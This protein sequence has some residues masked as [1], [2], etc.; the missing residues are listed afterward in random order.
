VDYTEIAVWVPPLFAES[1]AWHLQERYATGGPAGTGEGVVQSEIPAEGPAPTEV[2]VKLYRLGVEA[3]QEAFLAELKQDVSGFASNFP[4]LSVRFETKLVPEENWA[5]SWKQYWHPLEVGERLVI[6]PS[7]E[8]YEHQ[9]EKLVIELDPKQAFGTGTHPTTQLCLRS[10]ENIIPSHDKPTV[11]DVGTGS[12]IL[13]IAAVLLGASSVEA[14]DT[15]PVAVAATDENIDLNHVKDR[16][17]THVG[18]I[19]TLHGRVDVL[20]INILAEIVAELAPEIASRVRPGGDIIAS[21][22]IRERQELVERA[23][24]AQ[25]LGVLRVEHQGEWVVIEARQPDTFV[26][27]REA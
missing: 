1:L 22:I 10:L 17:R 20:V 13:A 27:E 21:G 18:G 6:K 8:A 5:H 2:A 11:F 16:I 26:I 23:F 25:G 9:G 14:C 19:E 15:D 3:E 12:G 4:G 24:E 7:W